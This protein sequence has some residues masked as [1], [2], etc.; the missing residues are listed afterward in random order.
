[1][2]YPGRDYRCRTKVYSPQITQHSPYLARIYTFQFPSKLLKTFGSTVP[3]QRERPKNS[4][5]RAARRLRSS[6]YGSK[7]LKTVRFPRF[8]AKTAGKQSRVWGIFLETI[9]S[10]LW[11]PHVLPSPFAASFDFSD[12]ERVYSSCALV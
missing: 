7:L 11:P 4:R 10:F 2:F 12:E 9:S 3:P 1:M 6:I 8:D 5:E